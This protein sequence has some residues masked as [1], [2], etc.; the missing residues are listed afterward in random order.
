MKLAIFDFDGTMFDKQSIP[1][2]LS[3]YKKM[4]YSKSRYY[5]FLIKVGCI[6]LKYKSPLSKG[7]T[8]DIFR[9]DAA[10]YFVKMFNGKHPD[11]LKNFFKECT[12]LILEDLNPVVL[13][14]LKKAQRDGYKTVLLSGCLIYLL[15]GVG[16]ELK[17][18]YVIGTDINYINVQDKLKISNDITVITG[19]KKVEKLKLVLSGKVIDWENSRAYADSLSD[20]CILQLVGNPFAINPDKELK[21]FA[22]ENNWIIIK[23]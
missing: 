2:L 17:M 11:E 19:A 8:R 9:K 3:C 4:K 21:L 20:L 18:D 6:A 13:N 15:Q 16:E 7:Y 10:L 12:P 14:E 1:Y 23:T 5:K 22:N